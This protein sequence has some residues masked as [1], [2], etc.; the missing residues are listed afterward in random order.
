MTNFLQRLGSLRQKFSTNFS[1]EIKKD[2]FLE[3]YIEDTKLKFF[4]VP[5]VLNIYKGLQFGDFLIA[6]YTKDYHAEVAKANGLDRFIDKIYHIPQYYGGVRKNVPISLWDRLTIPFTKYLNFSW[7]KD[8]KVIKKIENEIIPKIF[9][10][11]CSNENI[12]N[13]T[14]ESKEALKQLKDQIY[15]TEEWIQKEI[16]LDDLRRIEL[17]GIFVKN[18][19]KTIKFDME[20][21]IVLRGINNGAVRNLRQNFG[22][23]LE[24]INENG[25]WIVSN[26]S[27]SA[28]D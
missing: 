15:N 14:L 19:K 18:L 21:S 17:K 6:E 26:F 1:N 9:L 5:S 12:E 2:P 11:L 22:A 4:E 28:F 25:K 16:H 23:S 13:I 8:Y 7:Y 24:F 20:F 10:K 3:N 27:Y